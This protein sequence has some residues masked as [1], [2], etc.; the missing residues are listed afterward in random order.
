MP[1]T[2]SLAVPI[3]LGF[4]FSLT[5]KTRE[6]VVSAGENVEVTLPHNEVELNA[7][8]VPPPPNGKIKMPACLCFLQVE[9]HLFVLF[10][11][12]F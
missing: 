6:L 9:K 3:D 1:G 11:S 7:F 12:S 8:V 5:G 4:F 10:L 2:V